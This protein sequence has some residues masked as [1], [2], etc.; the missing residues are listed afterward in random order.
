MADAR[1]RASKNASG[2]RESTS[3]RPTRLRVM[4][5]DVQDL[6]RSP[7]RSRPKKQ[8]EEK[9]ELARYDCAF[10]DEGEGSR[11]FAPPDLVWGKV[12]S[13]PWW[14]GQVFDPADASEV[15]LQHRR[16]GAPL[17]AYFW[18][19][20]FAWNDASVLLPFRSNFTRFSAQSTMSGF[21][22]SVD[23]ALQ[24]VGRRVEVSLS[25]SCFGSTISTKQEVE[26]SGVRHG[27]Y[28]AVVD[29]RYLRDAFNCK[30]FLDYISAL[31]KRPLAGADLL[32]LATAKAQLRAFNRA[33][34]PRG[35][36]EFVLF[37]GIEDVADA[38][39]N[40]RKRMHKNNEND[41]LSKEKKSRLAGSSSRRS[42]ALLEVADEEVMYVSSRGATDE[43]ATGKENNSKRT[44]SSAKKKTDMSK[45]SDRHEI[46][47]AVGG[48][49]TPANNANA[50]LRK[51]KKMRLAESSLLRSDALLEV[52]DEEVMYVPSRGAT[53][54]D[55][56][57]K[58]NNSKCT[59]S[60]AK[61]KTDMSKHSDRREIAAAVGGS[62]TPANNANDV[63][64]KEKKMRLAGSSSLRSDA[65]LEVADEE[66]MYVPSRGA[67]DEDATGK[68]NNSKRTKS[69]AKKK[70]D[71]FKHSDRCERSAAVGG[72]RTPAKNES[73]RTLRSMSMKE[74]ALEG[75]KKLVK[76][77]G[78]E[79]SK[80]NSKDAPLL[81]E[82]KLRHSAARKKDKIT[83]DEDGLG[84]GSTKDSTSPGKTSSGRTE[85]SVSKRLL[86]SEHGRKKKKLSELMAETDR[87]NSAPYNKNKTRGTHLHVSSVKAEDPDRDSKD[88]STTRKRKKLNT[89]GDL[90]PQSQPISRK[91]S[92]K[93]GELMTKAS[94]RTSRTP[95]AVKANGTTSQTKLHSAKHKHLR[96]SVKSPRPAKL[97]QGKKDAITDQSLSCGEMLMQLSLAACDLK[98]R[99]KIAPTSVNFFT[100]FRRNSNVS[101]CDVDKELPE[102]ADDTESTPSEQPIADHMQDEYWAD[103]LINV[104]EP[105]ST[106]KKKDDS[107]KRSS[108][109]AHQVKKLLTNSSVA[110]ASAGKSRSGNKQDTENGEQPKDGSK[111]FV[112]DGSQLNAGTKSAEEFETSLLAGL[113]LHFSRP[114]A[115]PSLRDLIK[116]FSQYGPVKEAKAD[117]ANNANS[118]QVI[119]KRRMDAEAAFAGA[120]KIS[121]L[122]PAL[123]SFRLT[124][125]PAA[126]SENGPSCGASKSE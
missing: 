108:K 21:V 80:G 92:T 30:T 107:K 55:A 70:T 53:G 23:T 12:R 14:P 118:A 51:E 57:G 37:Q 1:E 10:Q 54:E 8:Q 45:H 47:V 66:V 119:F 75:L 115:V 125:F 120:G 126:A 98:R 9:F 17:V 58:G 46:A 22:S 85:N 6:L 40:T 81:K 95:P 112:V 69:S 110:L 18:D 102:K 73:V 15:A 122:G 90:S 59:K 113:V 2:D 105:L 31:G 13:H 94:G 123:D 65:L 43:D 71:M 97:N 24:E 19:R 82:N 62:R 61:K 28:G 29:S 67:T 16:P 121:A 91:K 76:D 72:S 3:A 86:I 103:I 26:N 117:I 41:V 52:A 64:R 89:L 49:R 39:P 109:K 35:L 88:T 32:D 36:P 101:S 38:V 106:L 48:S 96:A 63:L 44:K 74:D 68:G 100:G 84:D 124:D 79:T 116:I 99:A 56:M 42:E 4:R 104:E 60:L 20:T 114:S 34:G 93:V 78:G 111:L 25:C 83:E 77:G 27:A 50:V 5:A 7:R 33:R 11:D 87:P